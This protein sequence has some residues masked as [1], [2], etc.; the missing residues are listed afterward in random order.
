MWERERE[1]ERERR[2]RERERVRERERK[3]W[4]KGANLVLSHSTVQ[5]ETVKAQSFYIIR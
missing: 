3:R 1:R 5:F 2:E 4:R